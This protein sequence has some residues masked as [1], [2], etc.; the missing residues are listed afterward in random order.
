M[1][2]GESPE[3]YQSL[4]GGGYTPPT[5]DRGSKILGPL[6]AEGARGVTIAVVSTVVVFGLLAFVILNSSGWP[7]VKEAFFDPDVFWE[8]LGKILSKFGP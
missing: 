8:S 4:P 6:K 7:Q 2:G 1:I 3:K 5:G